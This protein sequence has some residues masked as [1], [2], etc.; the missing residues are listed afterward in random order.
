MKKHLLIICFLLLM[1]M[2]A[3]SQNF[4][5]WTGSGNWGTASNWSG[6]LDYGQLQFT[7]NGSTSVTANIGLSQWRLYFNNGVSYNISGSGALSLFDFSGQSSWL[8]SDATA[9]Q[10]LNFPVNF[11]DSGARPAWITTRGAGSLSFGSAVAVTGSSITALKIAGTNTNGAININGAFTSSRPLDIGKDNTNANQTNTR[12]FLNADNSST[13]TGPTTLY[14]GTLSVSSNNALGTGSLTI[15][16]GTVTNTLAITGTTAR[17]Q[18]LT[19][20][21]GST[22]GVVNVATGNTFTLSGLLQQTGTNQATKIGKA[23]AGV[24]TLS[25]NNT[26]AGQI[27]IGNGSVIANSNAALGSNTSTSNRGIDLGLNV[28]DVSQAN[29]VSLLANNGVTV[30]QSVYVSANTSSATRTIGLNGSGAATFNNFIY[31]DGTVSLNGGS[32]TLT[33]SGVLEN[34]GG[35]N[36]NGGTVVLSGDNTY[37]GAT[38]VTSGTLRLGAAN[39]IDGASPIVLAGGTFSSGASI[40]FTDTLGT[41]NLTASTAST[42][43]LGTGSHALTFANSSALSWGAGATLTITGWAGTAGLSNTTGGRIFVGTGGLSTAQL[44]AI[45]FSGYSGT[46]VILP[47]GELVPAGP[48]FAVTAGSLSHGSTCIN[49]AAATITYTI[50][51]TGA[52]AAGVTVLSDNSEFVVSNAPTA[53]SAGGTATY[54]VTFTPTASGSKN[55]TITIS[56]STSGSN[57]PVT[58]LLT[59][60]GLTII[61]PAFA[62]VPPICSG[63]ALSALPTTS[64]N[65]VTGTWSPALN[66]ATTTQYTFT[67]T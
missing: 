55:A 11:A 7:G 42:I 57:T 66:N 49:T 1:P 46:P 4:T 34:T 3:I 62:Q 53:I 52:A 63:A 38:T 60:T 35:I 56:T 23:G 15:G 25:G 17:T 59:G 20:S 19:V 2:F 30:G 31:M 13:F 8:L 12:V 48:T 14:A 50:S 41:L 28:G 61:T 24:L 45:A 37:T 47:S 32:G 5:S 44:A 39:R 22:A 64:T 33:I 67:P 40:G 43:A 51:N 21:D 36:V 26:Y 18:N 6:A 65:G 54:Q 16:N 9:N 58:S 29:N 10:D 27:Q